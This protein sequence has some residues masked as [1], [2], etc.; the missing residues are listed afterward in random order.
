MLEEYSKKRHFD[1]T[2]EPSADPFES[3]EGPL[4]FVIQKHDATRL[5]YDLRLEADGAMKSWA[6][7]KGPSLNPEDKHLAVM[8]EDH[9][10][11]YNNFEGQIPKGEYGGGEVIIWDRGT[12]YPDDFKYA[13]REQQEK[14]ILDGIKKGKLSFTLQ[15]VKLQGSWT[16]VHTG[17]KPGKE[18]EW[19]LI[20]HQDEHVSDHDI[21]AE[22]RSVVT[23]RTI[24]DVKAGR[25]GKAPAKPKRA[26]KKK[27]EPEEFDLA[28]LDFPGIRKTPVPDFLAPMV[29]TE[30]A[31]AFTSSD[32][33]FE[34]KL[35][36]IRAIAIKDGNKVRLLSRNGRDI[37]SKFPTLVDEIRSIP[38]REAVLDGE[39]VVFDDKGRPS[40]QGIIQRF[41]LQ[42]DRDIRAWDA[43][44]QV[45]FL[46]FDLLHLDGSDLRNVTLANR[47]RVLEKLNPRTR[48]IKVLD[49]YPEDGELLYE[50]AAKLGLEG[51]VGKRLNST[52]RDGTRSRDWIKVKGYHTEEFLIC[53]YTEGMGARKSTFGALLL[54]RLE[55]AKMHYCGSVGGGFSDLQLVEI[56]SMLEKLP[57]TKN[58]FGKALDVRGKPTFVEPQLVAEVRF[59]TW[60]KE[61]IL[62][63]PIFKRLRPDLALPSTLVTGSGFIASGEIEGVLDQ[64]MG[65]QDDLQ[66]TVD[67]FPL[68][69]T[70]LNK[71]LWPGN[72]FTPPITKR[73]L[74][75]YYAKISE[76]MLPH[77]RDRPL[78]FV[79]FP[80]GIGGES[81]FQKH[82]DKGRPEYVDTVNIFSSSSEKSKDWICCNNLSTLLWLGQVA[83][84]EIHPW[85]SRTSTEPDA[86]ELG[87]DFGSSEES[88]DDSVLNYPD[89]VVFDLD[90]VLKNVETPYDLDAYKRTAAV[91]MALK[92]VLDGLKLRSYVKTS[93]KTGLHIYV[94]VFRIYTYPEARAIAETIGRHLMSL[95]PKE[96]TMEWTVS[97][98]P[99]SKIFFDHNQNVRGKTLASVYSL[100][101]VL[102]APVSFPLRWDEVLDSHAPEFNIYTAPVMLAERGERWSELLRDRQKL[103][104]S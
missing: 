63:F 103:G 77:L 51:I 102:G 57:P 68:R 95:H 32:W 82:W 91:A 54:G 2:P 90:P 70:N 100:R 4:R 26:S 19:L 69:L 75:A 37:A 34:L 35:D 23:G 27:A 94:P 84:L 83:A 47:R 7:P 25:K 65:A 76:A 3:P 88:L 15:G 97:K 13:T 67:G 66:L 39:I 50:Q 81:F 1:K 101:P 72:D 9:P 45:D 61:R 89:F 92:E 41:S 71:P 30:V 44:A 14:A 64:L 18:D 96:V 59:M 17:R 56:R 93:G 104:F 16:L 53:G 28:F 87:T 36:G 79:R 11:S 43:S 86:H 78:S 6:V 99:T 42:N 98:R 22:D 48:C 5:H 8:V 12:Y 24:D 10:I 80:E 33:T 60:T 73:D 62:R 49:A 21:L 55:G 58:P 38:V 40:F 85:Y 20:K 74:I 29:P 52:Y 46:L 31:K